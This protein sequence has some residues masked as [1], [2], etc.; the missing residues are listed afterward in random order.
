MTVFYGLSLLVCLCLSLKEATFPGIEKA[1]LSL[2]TDFGGIRKGKKW[3]K[4]FFKSKR[5]S[6]K[7]RNEKRACFNV[8]HFLSKWFLN[9]KKIKYEKLHQC[10]NLLHRALHIVL[11]TGLE[12]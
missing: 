4:Y 2:Q 7:F 8:S 5:I 1:T 3:E 9:D 6:I 10:K 12:R 11:G